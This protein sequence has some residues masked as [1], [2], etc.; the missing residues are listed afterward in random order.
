MR[1][2]SWF[3]LVFMFILNSSFTLPKEKMD[4]I[5]NFSKN[6]KIDE[7]KIVNDVV[8]G[9]ISK[10]SF[11]INKNGNAEFKGTVSTENNGGFASVR[12]RFDKKDID[13]KSTIL[14]RLKGDSKSYQ[15]RLK[16]NSSDYF[17]YITS[18]STSDD[19]ETIKINLKDL[20]PSFRGRKLN[21][22]NFSESSIEEISFLISNKRNE[23][24]KLVIDK[25]EID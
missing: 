24:F 18:F 1:L 14:I 2:S 6:C 17:S 5:F 13:G 11:N 21:K 16:S 20:Y 25:I 23:S 4:T 9:G 15:F 7:W 8:M 10:A 22:A 19:W 12:Y 3:G